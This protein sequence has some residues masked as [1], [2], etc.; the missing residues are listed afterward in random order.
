[1][2]EVPEFKFQS[3]SEYNVIVNRMAEA[4]KNGRLVFFI[5]AGISRIQGYPSWDEYIDRLIK[6]WESHIND[7]PAIQK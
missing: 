1:M 4:L 5:G 3:L 6:Y 2:D 7:D